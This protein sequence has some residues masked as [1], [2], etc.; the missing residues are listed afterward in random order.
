[1]TSKV[2]SQQ[3]SGTAEMG[4]EETSALEFQR[5]EKYPPKGKE[6]KDNRQEE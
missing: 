3:K 2:L 6:K 5:S 1:M 4:G